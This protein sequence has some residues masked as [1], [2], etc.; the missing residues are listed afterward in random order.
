[1][2]HSV[3]IPTRFRKLH[4]FNKVPLI[5]T[6][7]TLFIL[8]KRD[9]VQD[10]LLKSRGLCHNKG[11][12]RMW[13]QCFDSTILYTGVLNTRWRCR[14]PTMCW[15]R[16]V[17]TED[18]HLGNQEFQNSGHSFPS[19]FLFALRLIHPKFFQRHQAFLA[20]HLVDGR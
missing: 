3:P 12:L 7:G 16:I 20:N 13:P 14:K 9:F 18:T 19:G 5:N 8:P 1:M 4:R 6:R 11:T 10:L 15:K 2:R 17:V